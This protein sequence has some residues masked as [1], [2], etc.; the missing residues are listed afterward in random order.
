MFWNWPNAKTNWVF[1]ENH[2]NLD[3]IN[4]FQLQIFRKKRD[5]HRLYRFKSQIFC[6]KGMSMRFAPART[7]RRAT[8]GRLGRW[9]AGS[10]WRQPR[11]TAAPTRMRPRG[12]VDSRRNGE[13]YAFGV[14]MTP[15]VICAACAQA[16]ACAR[17]S[18][19]DLPHPLSRG[20]APT[21]R[22]L[23]TAE[24][25]LRVPCSLLPWYPS[26]EP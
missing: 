19:C 20:A 26:T 13:R 24:P 6:K 1:T 16:M 8:L 25:P 17:L 11:Q 18:P 15:R 23:S 7:R 5:V 3:G 14:R 21:A 22:P 10:R 9:A 4:R 12:V 2:T